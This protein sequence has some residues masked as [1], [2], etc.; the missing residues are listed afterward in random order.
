VFVSNPWL[1]Y[2]AIYSE[3]YYNGKGADSKLNYVGEVQHPTRTV[4][5]YEWR[6]V[7]RRVRALTSVTPDTKWLD[8]GCGTGGL[9]HYL[10]SQNVEAVGYEQGW[11]VQLLRKNGIPTIDEDN[12]G[13]HR[14]YFDIVSAVEVI[15]HTPDPV[16]LLRRIRALLKPGG[17]LFMT[18]GNAEPF[19]DRITSWRYVTPDVHVSYFEPATLARA[20]TAA[21]FEPAFPGYGE[22]WKDIIRY[23]LLMTLRR[24]WCSPMES[25]V[26]WEALGRLVDNRLRLSAQP[27]GWVP[28]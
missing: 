1:E 8:F 18:T 22:G 9:V 27:V 7:L 24:K 14:G 13:G 17:L 4:R 2:D 12:F 10:R 20:L 11:C 6:G 3:E 5:R 23:K 28:N 16:A 26:P 15:E 19:R 21:G 25:V